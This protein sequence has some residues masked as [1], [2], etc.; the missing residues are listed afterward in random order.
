MRT[1]TELHEYFL[2][3]G[4][5]AEP[6]STAHLSAF[7]TAVVQLT[8]IM[9]LTQTLWENA[10]L[11]TIVSLVIGYLTLKS[12]VF[13]VNKHSRIKAL[14]GFAPPAKAYLPWRIFF[15]DQDLQKRLLTLIVE[16]DIVYK[17]FQHN[18]AC[19]MMEMWRDEFFGKSGAWTIEASVFG[20]RLVVTAEPDN[21]K[22]ILATQ[23]TDFGKGER[24]RRDWSDFLGD[25]IFTTDGAMWHDSRQLIR[26]QFARDRVSDLECFE[27]HVQT[28]FKVIANG[29]ALNGEDQQVDMS[30][31]DGRVV[32]MCDIFFRYTLDVATEFI[33]GS[34]V[35]SLTYVSA[36]T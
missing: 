3:E 24:F 19:K 28:L 35:K 8:G 4:T 17:V 25:S 18:K 26:P 31:A 1:L 15:P 23:F 21:I 13:R 12:I 9:T 11:G 6:Y 10:S 14:G 7:D 30:N 29:G 20:D 34:D 22:A 33:L 36:P 27:A 16:L 5:P 32:D 2:F